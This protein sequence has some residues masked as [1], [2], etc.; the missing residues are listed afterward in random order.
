MRIVYAIFKPDQGWMRGNANPML[1][2]MEVNLE[3]RHFMA[4]IPDVVQNRA[5]NQ[6]LFLLKCARVLF[7]VVGADRHLPHTERFFGDEGGGMSDE[8]GFFTGERG[9]FYLCVCGGGVSFFS[10]RTRCSRA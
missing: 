5:E 2:E 8:S 1:L 6:W 4:W 10:N 9:F 7:M 3:K